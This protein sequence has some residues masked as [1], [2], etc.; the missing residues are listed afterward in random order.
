V[1]PKQSD[2]QYTTF[3]IDA[4]FLKEGDQIDFQ[5][6]AV[7]GH[8]F[9]LWQ[10]EYVIDHY[11]AGIPRYGDEKVLVA[12][13]SITQ[14]SEGNWGAIQTLTINANSSMPNMLSSQLNNPLVISYAVTAVVVV[15]AILIPLLLYTR[16]RKNK[17]KTG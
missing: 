6:K 1:T 14:D 10:Y 3:P 7:I 2:G 13:P 17:A 9:N 12:I 5:V 4:N 11:F 16:H 8:T 15:L